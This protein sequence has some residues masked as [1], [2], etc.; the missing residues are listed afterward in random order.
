MGTS[1]GY[2]FSTSPSTGAGA[3]SHPYASQGAAPS[4]GFGLLTPFRRDKKSDFAAGGGEALVKSCV[5]Q[6]LGMAASDGGAN[7]GELPWRPELGSWLYKLRFHQNDDIADHIARAH[8]AEAISR[9]EPRVAMRAV[10][11]SKRTT[12]DTDDTLVV[13]MRYDIVA[14]N[15]PGN[16]VL[17]HDATQTLEI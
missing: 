12:H 1:F 15:A 11:T 7:M 5:S 14:S 10:T 4:L 3:A 2:V 8:V 13:H 6:V 17:L 9:W 16:Q